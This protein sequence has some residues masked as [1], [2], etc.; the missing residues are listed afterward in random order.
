MSFRPLETEWWP[1]CRPLVEWI[2]RTLPAGGTGYPRPQWNPTQ[3]DRLAERF[4]NS[5]EGRGFDDPDHRGLLNSVLWFAT[6]YGSGDPL[7]WSDV[8]IEI[9]L[10]D[11]LPRKVIAPIEYLAAAPELV[12]SFIRFAHHLSGV[13]RISP[14]SRR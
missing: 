2:T 11:W 9:L 7:H 13:R 4:F 5:Q 6:D 3:V 8:R 1:A 10:A 14:S 12:R